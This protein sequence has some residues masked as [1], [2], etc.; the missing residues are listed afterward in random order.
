[1]QN[2]ISSL[3]KLLLSLQLSQDRADEGPGALAPQLEEAVTLCTAYERE[4]GYP[5]PQATQLAQCVRDIAACDST[6]V[7]LAQCLH[8]WFA[9]PASCWC[10]AIRH[11]NGNALPFNT[12]EPV[13]NALPAHTKL[14]LAHECLRSGSSGAADTTPLGKWCLAMLDATQSWPFEEALQ[15]LE[16]LY[17]AKRV[18][19]IQIA[20][21]FAGQNIAQQCAAL[22]EN[23]P[24]PDMAE[25]AA[26]ALCVLEKAPSVSTLL[27]LGRSH[28]T[29]QINILLQALRS[30]PPAPVTPEVTKALLQLAQ[31]HEPQVRKGALFTMVV[32]DVPN[33]ATIF[34]LVLKKFAKERNYFYPALLYLSQDHLAE[35][36]SIM[37]PK[38]K[39]DALGYVL[40]LF[41]TGAQDLTSHSMTS[42]SSLL[43][44]LPAEIR[45]QIKTFILTCRKQRFL[46]PHAGALR[47]PR[48]APFKRT[49]QT[50]LFSKKKAS[51]ETLFD[52]A[53]AVSGRIAGLDAQLAVLSDRTLTGREICDSTFSHATLVNCTFSRCSFRRVSFH[54]ALL[55]GVTFE[56]CRFDECNISESV[57]TGCT[58]T[59]GSMH[60]V[61]A[62]RADLQR[63]NFTEY[64]AEQVQLTEAHL[65]SCSL[66]EVL[67]DTCSLWE[68]TLT[69]TR[70]Q[71]VHAHMTDFTRCA[72]FGS[73][74]LGCSF[75]E[76]TFLATSFERSTLEN[77]LSMAGNYQGCLF[78]QTTAD[79]PHLLMSAEHQRFNE[80]MDLAVSLP[81]GSVPAW[82][83]DAYKLG[84]HVLHQILLFRSVLRSRYRFL[85]QNSHR[86]ALTHATLDTERA[87]F[88]KLLP[89]LLCSDLYE[90]KFASG[91]KWPL[92]TISGYAPS[93]GTLQAARRIFDRIPPLQATE[94]ALTLDAVYT[95]GS[96]GSVAMTS[97]SDIDY[98][99]SMAPESYTPAHAAALTEKLKHISAWAET[100]FGL[101][102]TFFVMNRTAIVLNDFGISD[103]ESS[104]S[105]Q[106]LLLKEEFYRTALKVCGR[107]LAWWAMPTHVSPEA[108]AKRL[109]QVAALPFKSGECLVDFGMVQRIPH[110]EYFGAALWQ[111]VKA[112]KNPFKSVMKLGILEAYLAAQQDML[113]CETI[114]DRIISGN[115][116]LLNSDPYVTLIRTL[117]VHYHATT[118]KEAATLLQTAFLAKL[119]E[120]NAKSAGNKLME[121]L[122]KRA[123][124]TLYGS[125]ALLKTQSYAQAMALG[126]KL[127]TFFLKS[128]AN[129]QRQLDAHQITARISPEDVTR[130]G[131]KIFAA[132]APQQDK[133]T[134][135]PFVN[136]MGRTIRELM[137]KKDTTPGKRK[138]WIA[139]GLPQGV[140]S[141]RE[142]FVELRVESDPVRLMAWL[143]ANGLYYEGMHVEV[144]MT[145]SPIAAQDITSLLQ[146]LDDFFPHSVM[147]TDTEE[148]LRSERIRQ[149]YCVLNFTLPRDTSVLKQVS[150]VYVTN[151]GEMFCTPLAVDDPDQLAKRPRLF[152]ER[153]LSRTATTDAK[154]TYQ[155]P[156]KS[157]TPRISVA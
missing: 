109:R 83:H 132:F 126:D 105:A 25:R 110:E 114:K 2:I 67:I 36:L 156:Y 94:K 107:D 48:T 4:Q 29:S 154:L 56:N 135:L 42:A 41:M 71:A 99:V 35:F 9:M 50:S 10:H 19:N 92:C 79:E 98:W 130:L 111:I 73:T 46:E 21:R 14:L 127:N 38:L 84:E 16:R 85:R 101:E 15:F 68:A 31:H 139:L 102:T 53:C 78:R 45:Q 61:N 155:I 24:L 140:A 157:R 141:R 52:E 133:I 150:F 152:I 23:P 49:E 37:P 108:Y 1:M 147:E 104:G 66:R 20:E 115:R 28:D 128:Y 148:T 144:D 63:T 8:F 55:H 136:S 93:Y 22:A 123:I 44:S 18:L 34:L 113:L 12:C 82:C 5:P 32:L 7:L 75:T 89:L 3:R 87:T 76:S 40:H 91:K 62:S 74:L 100:Q 13:L 64:A 142:S 80:L 122:R 72:F 125:G 88:F 30:D 39:Q 106:A 51:P 47:E 119:H 26:K 57:L 124:E 112:F 6:G 90:R 11:L 146:G 121:T 134:R 27:K 86:I 97:D 138:K 103:K 149:V 153:H 137:F 116:S 118:N 43:K 120:A 131:R 65:H 129:L 117:H 58:F 151:W 95:I 81:P 77:T 54:K 60:R 96:V 33:L 70:L 145:M 69:R 143:I 59:E 17:H